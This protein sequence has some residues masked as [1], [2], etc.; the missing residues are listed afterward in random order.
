MLRLRL[1]LEQT[2]GPTY[3]TEPTTQPTPIAAE[4]EPDLS[5]TDGDHLWRFR[6]VRQS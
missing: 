1:P 4:Y 5:V 6:Y 2:Y 3:T